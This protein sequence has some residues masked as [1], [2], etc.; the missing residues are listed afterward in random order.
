MGIGAGAGHNPSVT[1]RQ[2]EPAP[3]AAPER[4]FVLAV[5]APG[6]DPAGELAEIH[7]LARTAGVETVGELVQHRPHPAARRRR[8]G[9][10][11]EPWVSAEGRVPKPGPFRF[12]TWPPSWLAPTKK[13]TPPVTAGVASD[14]TY[15][16]VA[17]AALTPS[18]VLVANS[19]EPKW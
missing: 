7:E 19:T 17:D 18:E 14:C 15:D 3:G 12:W 10:G 4:G 9:T 16:V 6:T 13:R 2:P 5:L 11:H 8:T 1:D